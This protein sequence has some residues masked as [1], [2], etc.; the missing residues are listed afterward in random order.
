MLLMAVPA[1][2]QDNRQ[3]GVNVVL[4]RL[5]TDTETRQLNEYGTVLNIY[6]EINVLTMRTTVGA[7]SEIQALPFVWSATPDAERYGGPIDTVPVEDFADGLST[8][9]L[10]AIDVA[11]PGFDNRQVA[12]DGPRSGPRGHPRQTP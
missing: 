7:I 4:N 8:W 2:A 9:N 3:L 12:Y 1:F 6:Y 11:D 10:D 5:V